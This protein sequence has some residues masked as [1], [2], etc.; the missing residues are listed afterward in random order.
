[1]IKIKKYSILTLILSGL[2]VIALI[3]G[4]LALTDIYH[5]EEDLTLEWTFLRIAALIFIIFIGSTIL[6]IVQVLKYDDEIK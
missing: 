2:S 3:I 5:Q 6:T 1:M 4:Y